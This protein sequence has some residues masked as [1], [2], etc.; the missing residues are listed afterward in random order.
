MTVCVIIDVTDSHDWSD[1]FGGGTAIPEVKRPTVLQANR[2]AAEREAQRLAKAHPNRQ[3]AIFEAVAAGI[4][5]K[6][7]T[8][9]NL[10]GDVLIQGTTT[11]V[12]HIGDPDDGIPF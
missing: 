12:V 5:I 11:A 8:H 2:P 1:R 9:V 6:V 10:K 3:F 7:P 4:T